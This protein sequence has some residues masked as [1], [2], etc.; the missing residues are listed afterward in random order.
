MLQKAT[1]RVRRIQV[2]IKKGVSSLNTATKIAK[3]KRPDPVPRRTP[4]GNKITD[5]EQANTDLREA[6]KQWESL[7][8]DVLGHV[9]K[10]KDTLNT[11][12]VKK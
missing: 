6:L 3:N 7:F 8:D 2:T 4:T 11:E 10:A 1:E 9:I 12:N 5:L